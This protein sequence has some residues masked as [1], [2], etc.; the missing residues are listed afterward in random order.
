MQ[1]QER[2]AAEVIAVQMG[3]H[4]QVDVGGIDAGCLQR[5]QAGGAAIDQ[6]PPVRILDRKTGVEPAA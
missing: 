3:Q 2:Q 5:R 6:E 1:Q 4:S